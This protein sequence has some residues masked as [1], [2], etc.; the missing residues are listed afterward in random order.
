M[1]NPKAQGRYPVVFKAMI[2][3]QC[4][5]ELADKDDVEELVTYRCLDC[6]KCQR[7]KESPRLKARIRQE[8]MEQEII[9]CSVQVNF[10]DKKVL[11]DLPFLKDPVQ[12]LTHCHGAPNNYA[13]AP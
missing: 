8:E 9:E 7:C 2:P 10:D 6:A 4:L 5:K 12:S 11:V 1:Q 13:Q 3:I